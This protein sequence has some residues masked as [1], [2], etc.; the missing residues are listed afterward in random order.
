MTMTVLT[1]LNAWLVDDSDRIKHVF[2]E[3]VIS[4]IS[5]SHSEVAVRRAR[6]VKFRAQFREITWNP[7][8][9]SRPFFTKMAASMNDIVWLKY[10]VFEKE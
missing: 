5:R 3:A 6:N 2:G 10:R 8:T 1:D 7:V 9:V 4:R